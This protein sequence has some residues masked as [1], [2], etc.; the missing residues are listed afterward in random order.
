MELWR[1]GAV[2]IA[3]EV[4]RKKGVKLQSQS[5]IHDFK[6]AVYPSQRSEQETKVLFPT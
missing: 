1:G 4:V 3:V 6:F 2:F 5:M